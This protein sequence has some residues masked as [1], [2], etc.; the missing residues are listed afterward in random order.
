MI[1]KFLFIYKNS[2]NARLRDRVILLKYYSEYVFWCQIFKV[3]KY[4]KPRPSDRKLSVLYNKCPN[5]IPFLRNWIVSFYKSKDFWH[6]LAY[7]TLKSCV[8]TLPLWWL[9]PLPSLTKMS[10]VCTYSVHQANPDSP[11]NMLLMKNI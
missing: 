5:T 11:K 2:Q 1:T 4:C 6:I 3:L 10:Y 7:M 9:M 8:K